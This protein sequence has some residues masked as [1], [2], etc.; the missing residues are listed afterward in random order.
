[1]SE[2]KPTQIK[3]KAQIDRIRQKA[4]AKKKKAKGSKGA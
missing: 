4:A 3:S 1:M 2:K